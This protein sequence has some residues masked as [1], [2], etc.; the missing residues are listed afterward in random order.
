MTV[1][2]A[3]VVAFVL[4][5]LL[6]GCATFPKDL[7][8]EQMIRAADCE[9]VSPTAHERRF[10]VATVEQISQLH[11]CELLAYIGSDNNYHYFGWYTKIEFYHDQPSGLAVARASFEPEEEFGVGANRI[12]EHPFP[13]NGQD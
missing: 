12:G 1:S 2:K 7:R 5:V 9:Q 13:I 11:K 6:A 10:S 3:W 8:P 4:V